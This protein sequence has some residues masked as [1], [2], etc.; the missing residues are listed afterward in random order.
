MSLLRNVPF[1]LALATLPGPVAAF[2]VT[3][4]V[5][6]GQPVHYVDQSFEPVTGHALVYRLWI[7][8]ASSFTTPG[9]HVVELLVEDDRGRW[10]IATRTVTVLATP[11]PSPALPPPP[12]VL[13]RVSAAIVPSRLPRGGS[14]HVEITADAPIDGARLSLPPSFDRTLFLPYLAVAYARWNAASPTYEGPDKVSLPI[15]VPWSRTTPADGTYVLRCLV[16]VAG[17]RIEVDVPLQVAGTLT[18]EE[19]ETTLASPLTGR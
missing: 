2:S 11:A 3:S 9:P 4:P 13:P 1:L 14:G 5:E 17:Q 18:W 8:R 16:S 10:G 7:G 12:P 6:V 19:T 15:Y